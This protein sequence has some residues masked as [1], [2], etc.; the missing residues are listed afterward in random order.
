[1]RKLIVGLLV[2]LVVGTGAYFGAVYW[3]ER[4]AAREVDARLDR[5]RSGGG[6]ATR[7]RVAFDLWTRTVRV[8]DVELQSPASANERIAIEEVVASGIDPSGG[9]SRIDIV[10]LE[11]SHALPGLAG[12]RVEQKAPRVTLTDFSE[13]PIARAKGASPVDAMRRWLEQLSA[14]SAASIEAPSLTV[15]VAPA[16]IGDRPDLMGTAEHTYSNLVLR[17]VADGRIAE[18]SVDKVALRGSA[19]RTSRGFTGEI[20]NA[21]VRDI[22]MGPVLAWLDPSRPREEGYRRIYGQLDIGPYTVRFDDGTGIGIDKIAAEEIG[23]RPDRL[24]LDDL[25]FLMEVARPGIAPPTTG[26]LSMLV[27]KMAGLYEGIHLGR[28]ELQGVRM[29]TPL[30]NITIGSLALS[31]LDNGRLTELSIERLEGQR[32][33]TETVG[34]GR[35]IVEKLDGRT[36]TRD[37]VSLGR[38]SLKGFDIA[39][40]FR[41]ASTQLASLGQQPGAPSPLMAMFGLIEGIEI[42]DFA[43]P[44]P[45][46]GRT[47]QVEAFDASWGKLVGGIPSEGRLSAKLSGPVAPTDPDAFIRALAGRGIATLA[48]SLDLGAR[49]TEADESVVLAPA[50]VEIRNV[51]ALSIK[52]SA[53]KVSREMLTTDILKVIGGAPLVEA[54]PVELTI[55]DLGLVELAAAQLGQSKGRDAA[56]GRALLV[57][58]LAQRAA[59]TQTSPEL[60]PVLDALTRFVQGKGETLTVA[61][62][63]KGSVGLLQLIE[64]ARHDAVGALLANFTVE[65]RTGG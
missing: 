63:P 18:A 45:A 2:T 37:G 22:D 28:L 35:M 50:T 4:T 44:D 31:G 61:L 20:A 65:A 27:D 49:W 62:T 23:L 34:I 36:V 21:S 40:L 13:R 5:W 8:A 1:M 46:T 47:V 24:L 52:A 48:V 55:R 17:G 53:S 54:G 56:A 29:D 19:G 26:Q 14:I 43:A 39:N 32:R 7:G 60:Q 30:E 41:T 59:A 64:G 3:A 58:S 12:V 10:G 9:A 11:M 51:L 25:V 6:T 42:R 57:E 33:A 38:L 16:G 15:M